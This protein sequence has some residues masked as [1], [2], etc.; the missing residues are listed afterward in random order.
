MKLIIPIVFILFSNIVFAQTNIQWQKVELEEKIQNKIRTNLRNIL[1][2]SQYFLEVEVLINEPGM[3]NFDDLKKKGAKVSDIKFDD[4]QGD[5]IAFSKIGLEVPVV[6]EL[7]DEHQQKLKE[8]YRFQESFDLFKNITDVKVNVFTSDLLTPE[9]VQFAKTVVDNLKFPV[10]DI[11][12]KV[13]F[14][15]VKIEKKKEEPKALDQPVK[16]PE[17]EK[18]KPL[19]M[20][21]IL[22]FVSRFGN[23][24]GL[25][26]AT[27]LFGVISFML[28]K[29]WE[30]INKP[31]QQGTKA[32]SKEDKTE[33]E[34]AAAENESA[35]DK[36]YALSS[37][38]NFAR[39]RHFTQTSPS[40]AIILLKSWINEAN[41][42]SLSAIKA[43]AQQLTDEELVS[44]FKGL[45]DSER[46]K[47]KDHLDEFMDGKTLAIA[48]KFVCEEVVRT[49]IDPGKVNDLDVID[50][51]LNL[52]LDV[53]CKFV[54][55]KPES[56]KVLMN[57]LNPQMISKI[58][59]RLNES[60]ANNIMM[61]S[62]DFDF[63]EV[64]DNFS[65]F[66]VE[67]KSY[68]ELQK[69]KPFNSKILQM[70]SDFNPLKEILLYSYLGKSGMYDEMTSV[71]KQFLPFACIPLL[72]KE[73]LKDIMQSY[74][75][76]KKVQVL[77]VC[78]EELKEV[79][80]NAFA[81]EGSSARQMLDLEFD[82]I[83]GNA[84]ALSKVE[85]Q[86]DTILKDFVQFCR[87]F[88]NSNKQYEQD[89]EV[90]ISEWVRTMQSEEKANLKLVS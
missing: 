90:L 47:W 31:E 76:A 16:K 87:D 62:M 29:K 48:N 68:M 78:E 7:F 36:M 13:N 19:T 80:I 4:S 21:D 71:A 56:G 35:E 18:E 52:S 60:D 63:A 23:A 59:N 33:E 83:T 66:K 24:F 55:E 37:E 28:L 2:P 8:M 32:E 5:Y 12:P 22:D 75:M 9:Q 89:I 69:R 50:L 1:E 15:S 11:K 51:V 43:V 67:L 79:L 30:L 49:M 61:K 54:V 86:K 45:N 6:E 84:S 27:I 57:L 46:E 65:Q 39:F 82:N 73:L 74:P 17:V 40:E 26:L 53:A 70:V 88:V 44:L 38:E 77:T 81:V 10:G 25:I 72:S 85:A 42:Q 64:T 58:L 20:K 14:A 41:E 34:A 3:P